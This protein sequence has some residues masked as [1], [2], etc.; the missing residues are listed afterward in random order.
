MP[1]LHSRIGKHTY[2][3]LVDKVHNRL[4]SWKSKLLSLAGR[5]TLIQAVT[6]SI[7]VYA[8]QT[9]KLPV[10]VCNDLD[11]FVNGIWLVNLKQAGVLT[12]HD[13]KCS[14]SSFSKNG[15]WDIDKLRVVLCEDLV[16]QVISVP[17]GLLGSLPDTQI[18]KGSA[19][20]NF[21]VSL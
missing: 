13:S 6:A 15:W 7:P 9:T 14:I 21:S 11:I 16:Q 10:S 20:D 19:N 17:V 8:M 1:L 12:I 18:W 5:A 2:S 4:A 3:S